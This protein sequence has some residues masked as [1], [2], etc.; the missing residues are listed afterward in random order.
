[1]QLC[2]TKQYRLIYVYAYILAYTAALFSVILERVTLYSAD[3]T[4][5]AISSLAFCQRR[6]LDN[7]IQVRE[8]FSSVRSSC[9][10]VLLH[11]FSST[12]RSFSSVF[13]VLIWKCFSLNLIRIQEMLASNVSEF[14]TWQHYIYD[15]SITPCDILMCIKTKKF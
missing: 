4:Y 10:W 9:L 11:L 1:M 7:V 6:C 2:Y 12:R 13:E 8:Q 15:D 14:S 3:T 5:F